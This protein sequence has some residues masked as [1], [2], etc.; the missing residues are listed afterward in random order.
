MYR[1]VGKVVGRLSGRRLGVLAVPS[2]PEHFGPLG[3]RIA[4]GEIEVHV[5]RRVALDEVPE[6]L[7][8]VGAGE[9]LGKVVVE[10][11]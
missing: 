2:G 6:A 7:A 1:T 4:A 10:P 3:E 11:A 9:V 8:A 5:D